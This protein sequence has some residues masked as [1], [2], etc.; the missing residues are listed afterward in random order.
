MQ[1]EKLTLDGKLN[2]IPF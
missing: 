1:N 2:E